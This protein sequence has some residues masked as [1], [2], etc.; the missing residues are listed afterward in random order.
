MDRS[1]YQFALTYRGGAKNDPLSS[2]A[3]AMFHDHSF[4]KDERSFD[5]LSRYI[6]EKADS[7]MTS[8]LFDELFRHYEERFL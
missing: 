8:I 5:S 7:K 4:P 6:E 1:F 3:E 2:F